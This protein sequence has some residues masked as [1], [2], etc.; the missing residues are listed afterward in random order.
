V[1][2]KKEIQKGTLVVE[3][4]YIDVKVIHRLYSTPD[5]VSR[6]VAYTAALIDYIYG[7]SELRF[8]ELVESK[9]EDAWRIS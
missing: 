6:N 3:C 7:N 9:E 4:G 8:E 2:T 1:E 5:Q